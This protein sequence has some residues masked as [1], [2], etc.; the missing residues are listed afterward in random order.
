MNENTRGT[1]RK[2]DEEFKR[3]ALD[4][5]RTSGRSQKAVAAELGIS[6]TSLRDW[7]RAFSPQGQEESR[8]G[9][10]TPAEMEAE[11]RR[12]RQE[13]SSL[14]NQRDILKK[15]LG[16]LCEPLGNGSRT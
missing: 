9:P 15:S 8:G 12:L 11:I 3:A 4:L 5:W 7:R 14:R 16:I 10:Q 6:D 1:P 2:F 13:V